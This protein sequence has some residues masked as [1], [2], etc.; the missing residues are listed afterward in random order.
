MKAIKEKIVRII[1]N[2]FLYLLS[3]VVGLYGSAASIYFD[4]NGASVTA[5]IFG[6]VG[7]YFISLPL[8]KWALYDLEENYD[9][10]VSHPLKSPIK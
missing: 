3:T 2:S 9:T 5:L 8:L 4:N 6:I 10:K 7:V 1:R